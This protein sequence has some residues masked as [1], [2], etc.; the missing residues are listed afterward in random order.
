[1][2]KIA[3]IFH[4]DRDVSID[5]PLSIPLGHFMSILRTDGYFANESVFIPYNAIGLVFVYD[6]QEGQNVG[7]VNNVVF[8][9]G[10]PN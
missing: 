7:D 2:A 1:M 8:P 9:F 4:A 5:V 10:K 6:Q 3:R